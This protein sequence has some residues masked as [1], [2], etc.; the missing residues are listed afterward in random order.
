MLTDY[1]ILERV[2]EAKVNDMLVFSQHVTK[3]WKGCCTHDGEPITICND[4]I[5]LRA[6][7]HKLLTTIISIFVNFA[8]N[9][10]TNYATNLIAAPSA[11][12]TQDVGDATP[13]IIIFVLFVIE[14][15]DGKHFSL[16][17]QYLVHVTI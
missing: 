8:S 17:I 14:A 4:Q 2:D 10:L 3:L 7:L 11:T 15:F 1:L 16:M 9:L 13:N 6:V 5:D 12:S